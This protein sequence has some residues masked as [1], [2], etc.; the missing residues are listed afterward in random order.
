MSQKLKD[1]IKESGSISRQAMTWLR[2]KKLPADPLCYHVAYELFHSPDR[3]LKQR[4]KQLN[5]TAG[6]I[7][8]SVH[9]I[10]EDFIHSKLEN[11]L[12]QFSR[13]IDS[14]ANQTIDSVSDTKSHLKSFSGALEEAQPILAKTSGDAHINVI[15]LLISETKNIHQYAGKLEEK[16]QHAVE[17]IHELQSEHMAFRDRANR[18][19]LTQI[20]NRS[21]LQDAYDDIAEQAESYPMAILI[22]DIDHFKAFNDNHGHLIG[23]SVLK[24][25]A[26]TL[27]TNLKRRD[28]LARFGGEEF[29]ILLPNTSKIDGQTVADTLRGQI[30]NLAIRKKNSNEIIGR[31]C[32]SIGISELSIADNLNDAI[33]KAD[34]A[35][36]RAKQEG[37]NCVRVE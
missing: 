30:E 35:L 11:N 27:K 14:I 23:D 31:I 20:L 22:A 29:L 10:Y 32:L 2:D 21:G 28:I 34:K 9:Q 5:G 15:S 37:R 3:D 36:Y 25:V 24:V 16:L 13:K 19:P 4:V 7:L 17:E 26:S 1:T 8:E 18:D 33:D 12:E 6:E